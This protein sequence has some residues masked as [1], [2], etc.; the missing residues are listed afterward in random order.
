MGM[1]FLCEDVHM[2]EYLLWVFVRVA[3]ASESH[4]G[5]NFPWSPFKTLP[6]TTLPNFHDAHHKN[7]LGNYGSFFI[8]WDLFM[9][10]DDDWILNHSKVNPKRG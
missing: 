8:F 7:N 5:Y 9:H 3:K 10:T 2:I 1:S 4:S 6:W